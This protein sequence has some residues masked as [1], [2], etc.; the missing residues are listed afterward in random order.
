MKATSATQTRR[1]P[2]A[3]R[4]RRWFLAGILALTPLFVSVFVIEW[5]LGLGQKLIA[6]LPPALRPESWLGAPMPLLGVAA[7]VLFVLLIGAITTHLLGARVMRMIDRVMENIPLVRTLHRATRQLLDAVLREDAEAFQQVV[8]APFPSKDTRV[9]GFVTGRMRTP[10]G[11]EL[12]AVFVPSTPVPSTGWLLFVAPE[13]IT[14]LSISIDDAMKLVLS[15]GAL[16][17]EVQ[18]RK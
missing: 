3:R 16:I 11:E 18:R 14:P 10:E 13:E 8:L 17:A 5:L 9:I 1:H 7:V 6:L 12:V 2:W 4:L 15:G